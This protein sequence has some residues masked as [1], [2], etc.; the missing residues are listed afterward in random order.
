[1]DFSK[2]PLEFL[3]GLHD[4]CTT[5][6]FRSGSIAGIPPGFQG[7]GLNYGFDARPRHSL[8]VMSTDDRRS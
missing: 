4:F 1:M 2:C 3:H 5:D 8:K 7:S 6:N